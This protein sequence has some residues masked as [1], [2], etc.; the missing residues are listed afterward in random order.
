MTATEQEN[1]KRKRFEEV[2][3][4]FKKLNKE[5]PEAF[6]LHEWMLGSSNA[7]LREAQ[8]LLSKTKCPLQM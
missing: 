5:E 6:Y 4:Y 7:E 8:Y 1:V 2:I 3:A